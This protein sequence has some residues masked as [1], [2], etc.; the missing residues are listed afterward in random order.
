MGRIPRSRIKNADVACLPR[1]AHR[2]PETRMS[3]GRMG[4]NLT[5]S[6]FPSTTF[7]RLFC[8]SRSWSDGDQSIDDSGGRL[9]GG[10][11]GVD[12]DEA[13][14]RAPTRERSMPGS[15][16]FT[17]GVIDLVRMSLCTDDVSLRTS[18]MRSVLRLRSSWHRRGPHC[19]LGV[20]DRQALECGS[21]AHPPTGDHF[22]SGIVS[23]S[24]SDAANVART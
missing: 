8:L 10:T 5:E 23:S 24:D 14:G 18:R 15:P 21:R 4:I 3:T 22:V 17:D 19:L 20:E 12:V 9:R 1:C 16:E 6:V 2:H 13:R 7:D 11:R